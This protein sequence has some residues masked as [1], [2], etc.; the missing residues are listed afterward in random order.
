MPGVLFLVI[1]L[2]GLLALIG[3]TVHT[4]KPTLDGRSYAL[5]VTFIA[6]KIEAGKLVSQARPTSAKELTLPS[7][8][9]VGLACET[10]GK[11]SLIPR[12]LQE[13]GNG[14]YILQ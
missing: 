2:P 14:S 5:L 9:E 12:I 11:H 13:H 1:I 10:T 6:Q 3:V 7:F 4:L 8:V